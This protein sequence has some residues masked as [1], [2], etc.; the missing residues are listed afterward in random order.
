MDSGNK[1][2]SNEAAVKHINTNMQ[3]FVY[4][5]GSFSR[6]DILDY[7]NY[8][9]LISDVPHPILNSIIEAQL[10]TES[11][12]SDIEN[13]IAPFKKNHSPVFWY[14]WP[15][16]KPTN[17][18]EHL[19]A[20]GFEH[21]HDSPGMLANLSDLP[22]DLTIPDGARM[23][24]VSNEDKLKEWMEPFKA[25]Y[26]FPDM[27]NNFFYSLLKDFGY[28]EDLPIQNYLAYFNDEPVA[29]V[30]LYLGK[31]NVAG[32][33]NVATS[34]E[35]RGKGIGTAITWKGCFEAFQKGYQHAILLSSEMG[36][37]VYKRLG[38]EEYCKVGYY[39]WQPPDTE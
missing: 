17:L 27:F 30:T 32:I 22:K 9:G 19:L 25:G 24:R 11:I 3:E 34:P 35:A 29:C 6:I 12:K 36:Y 21:S 4:D 33:W 37:N 15:T 16:S 5:F 10:K 26:Q 28:A 18:S 20:Y 39:L 1:H 7:V 23:E 31:N 38:F 2:L 13:I 14:I 8:K